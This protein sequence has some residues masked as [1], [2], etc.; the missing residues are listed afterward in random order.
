MG[1]EVVA[2]LCLVDV[3]VVGPA[4]VVHHLGHPLVA[5]VLEQHVDERESRVARHDAAIAAL[6]LESHDLR[7]R[8]DGHVVVAIARLVGVRDHRDDR[9]PTRRSTGEMERMTGI[10]PA[11][12]AWEADVLPLNYI[13]EGSRP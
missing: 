8:I 13:R 7:R 6:G 4:V 11:F 2:L 9:W 5:K 10:E 3:G 1:D 12:S